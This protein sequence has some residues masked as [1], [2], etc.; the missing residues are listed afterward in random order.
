MG[1][2]AGGK[3]VG[4]VW[5]VVRASYHVPFRGLENY[6]ALITTYHLGGWKITE[7][8]WT[9]V[10]QQRAFKTNLMKLYLLRS[11][12]YTGRQVHRTDVFRE[13]EHWEQWCSRLEGLGRWGLK[14]KGFP[15][16]L[17]Q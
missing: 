9:H 2:V 8:S 16:C 14:E 15:S 17:S 1:R 12:S 7:H 5:Y 13:R 4:Y 6:R 3:R 11:M 10:C